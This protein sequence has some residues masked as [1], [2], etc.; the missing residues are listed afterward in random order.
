MSVFRNYNPR[1]AG[2]VNN[3]AFPRVISQPWIPTQR[4]I[5]ANPNI[6]SQ[7]QRIQPNERGTFYPTS[8][9]NSGTLAPSMGSGTCGCAGCNGNGVQNMSAPPPTASQMATGATL[10]VTTKA[11][12]AT[13]SIH[14]MR[15]QNQ[16]K[17][18]TGNGANAVADFRATNNAQFQGPPRSGGRTTGALRAPT[19][20]RRSPMSTPVKTTMRVS[21]MGGRGTR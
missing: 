20:P 5:R 1:S 15:P 13:S 16:P 12:G 9:D 8:A 11:G 4:N 19:N 21:L 18:V 7:P 3:N 14:T 10:P 2:G 17:F 6:P